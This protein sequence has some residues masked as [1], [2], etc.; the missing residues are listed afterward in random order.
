MTGAE[1][2]IVEVILGWGAPGIIILGLIYDRWQIIKERD[3]ERERVNTLTDASVEREVQTA[4]TMQ[5]MLDT[6]RRLESR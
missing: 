5:G 6:L 2:T 4:V 3:R 1:Q